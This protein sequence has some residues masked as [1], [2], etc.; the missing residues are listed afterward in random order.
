[1]GRLVE[2]KVEPCVL[3]GVEFW[4]RRR[5]NQRG[6]RGCDDLGVS[7]GVEDGNQF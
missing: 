4:F 1:M 7:I 3:L 5:E 6:M 2:V